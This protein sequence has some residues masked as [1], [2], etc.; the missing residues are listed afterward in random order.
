VAAR[1]RHDFVTPSWLLSQYQRLLV[2]YRDEV[3][4]DKGLS[5]E[6]SRHIRPETCPVIHDDATLRSGIGRGHR[7]AFSRK[8]FDGAYDDKLTDVAQDIPLE[9]MYQN[10]LAD[11]SLHSLSTGDV[12]AAE[13][14]GRLIPQNKVLLPGG[15]TTKAFTADSPE[16]VMK[17]HVWWPDEVLSRPATEHVTMRPSIVLAP[18]RLTQ[19]VRIL[20]ACIAVSEPIFLHHIDVVGSSFVE[21]E[22]VSTHAEAGQDNKT[23]PFSL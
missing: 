11:S 18:D 5:E 19:P 4:R 9:R 22:A 15:V 2:A 14:L 7:L 10:V 6:E 20:A 13:T 16:Q 1:L 17:V 21:S 23:E 12:S 3:A 8:V